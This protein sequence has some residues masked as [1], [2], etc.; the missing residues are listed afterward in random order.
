MQ[1]DDHGAANRTEVG[2]ICT[3]GGRAL[4]ALLCSMVVLRVCVQLARSTS[5][6]WSCA[7]ENDPEAYHPG[8]CNPPMQVNR[9]GTYDFDHTHTMLKSMG[10]EVKLF[11]QARKRANEAKQQR[12]QH[13]AAASGAC[14]VLQLLKCLHTALTAALTAVLS[15]T[16]KNKHAAN[17]TEVGDGNTS[18]A[19]HPSH[20]QGPQAATAPL[21]PCTTGRPS[22]A[23]AA[24]PTATDNGGATLADPVT[25]TRE[26]AARKERF[27]Q[28]IQG[29]SYLAPLTTVGNLPFRRL[30]K[31]MGADITCG[32]MALATNLLQAQHSE[33]ALLRRHP[34]EDFFGVQV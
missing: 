2:F 13:D 23:A 31:G 12:R 25:T 1:H 30:C 21:L 32:E 18:E 14:C 26:K 3:K 8:L 33:W 10:V 19:A 6:D 16:T 11:G 9:R 22:S 20:D 17:V 5:S 27:A 28:R 29:K 34:C 7:F 15:C 24:P 4:C